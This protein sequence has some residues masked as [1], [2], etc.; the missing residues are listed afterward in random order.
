M[1]ERARNGHFLRKLCET[2]ED[3]LCW[4]IWSIKWGAWHR[5]SSTGGAAGYTDNLA[6]AG[7]FPFSIAR[8]Y[9]D[10]EVNEAFHASVVA[11]RVDREV[12]DLDE[13]R[14]LLLAIK[15]AA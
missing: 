14:Q 3:Q 11:D 9:H 4:L 1:T 13:R 12:A 10:G 6:H 8:S 2:P 5:R 7:L 15:K